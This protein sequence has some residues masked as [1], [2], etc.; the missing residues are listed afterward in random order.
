MTIKKTELEEIMRVEPG[1]KKL[2]GEAVDYMENSPGECWE[3]SR[4]WYC[5]L[6]PRF[7]YFVGFMASKSEVNSCEAYDLAYMEFCKVLKI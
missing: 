1:L 2:M 7:K 3:R 4:F 6:K 5:G